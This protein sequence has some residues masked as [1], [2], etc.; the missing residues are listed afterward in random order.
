MSLRIRKFD[1]STMKKHRIILIVGKRGTGKSILQRDI[2]R[3]ISEWVDVTAAFTPTE[4]TASVYRQHMPDSWIHSGYDQRKLD[5]LL[6]VQRKAA[7][8]GKR[9]SICI[10]M[11][12]C[13]YDK[14][15]LKG[16]AIRDL[17]MNG[18]HLY[19]TFCTAAQYV[20]DIG[21]DLRTNVDYI[22]CLRENII[23]NKQKLWKYFFG[24]FERYDD[25]S[26]VMDGCTENY[27]CLVMDN[28]IGSTKMEDCVF[29]YK[30]DPSPPPFQMGNQKFL[31][32][33]KACEKTERELAEEEEE[34]E[35]ER[36]MLRSESSGRRR[37]SSVVREDEYGHMVG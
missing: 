7:K 1:P 14:Q 30:A 25:F 18:R 27:S 12:D 21:P 36:R 5:S 4:D 37:I 16:T 22:F 20:M 8:D 15:I 26:K 13:M 6:N 23:S 34:V 3:Y 29:W 28:T 10:L 35:R 31:Q 17:F 11:D 2:M 33:A 19:L 9:N 24:M 32:M